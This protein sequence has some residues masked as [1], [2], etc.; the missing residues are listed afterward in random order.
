VIVALEKGGEPANIINKTIADAKISTDLPSYGYL[1]CISGAMYPS[2]PSTVL[3]LPSLYL[4]NNVENPKSATFKLKFES[5][6][7]FSGLR[8]L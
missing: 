2:V 8:S 4:S 5:K 6:R 3:N 7:R 1:E